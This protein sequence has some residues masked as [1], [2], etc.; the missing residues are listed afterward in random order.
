MTTDATDPAAVDE[1]AGLI[2]AIVR[3]VAELPDRT[4]PADRPEMMLVDAEELSIIL[5]RHLATALAE[6]REKREREEAA[7]QHDIESCRK[8]LNGEV[9]ESERLRAELASVRRALRFGFD[10]YG[11]DGPDG[12]WPI[13][14]RG[15]FDRLARVALGLAPRAPTCPNREC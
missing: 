9:E 1:V 2:S 13:D 6:T 7:Y 15:A 3:D 4:S 14:K 12:Y 11:Y 8:S 5:E 10:L